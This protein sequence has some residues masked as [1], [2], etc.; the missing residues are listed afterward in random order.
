MGEI[1]FS[2]HGMCGTSLS[3]IAGIGGFEW[4]QGGGLC[5]SKA[6]AAL[7]QPVQC[8]LSRGIGIMSKWSWL[9]WTSFYQWRDNRYLPPSCP[10][11]FCTSNPPMP[12]TYTALHTPIHM[13][14]H[15]HTPVS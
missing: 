13:H 15:T 8:W 3:S 12:T 6:H 2:S 10:V 4:G 1:Y 7:C 5:P 11:K 14:T 9:C